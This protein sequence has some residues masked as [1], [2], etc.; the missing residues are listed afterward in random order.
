MKTIR[1]ETSEQ[2][3]DLTPWLR[4]YRTDTRFELGEGTFVVPGNWGFDDFDHVAL[5]PGCELI[6]AGSGR[7]TLTFPQGGYAHPPDAKQVECF[8]AGSRSGACDF[9]RIEGVSIEA[10]T[11]SGVASVGLH[12]WSDSCVVRD[13]AL[14]DISGSRSVAEG[15]GL[16]VNR[17]GERCGTAGGG[18]IE[19]V[20]VFLEIPVFKSEGDNYVCGCYVGIE[21]ADQPTIVRDVRVINPVEDVPA[22]AAFGTN[23]GV[24]WSGIRNVG[25]WRRAVFCDTAGGSGTLISGS[26]LQ[27]EN[28][29][30]EFRGGEN[31]KWRDIVVSGSML[32]LVQSPD[33]REYAA[34]LVLAT[35]GAPGNGS[36]AFEGVRLHG[37]TLRADGPSPKPH[38]F[39]FG[40]CDSPRSIACGVIQCHAVGNWKAPI[41]TNGSTGFLTSGTVRS[42]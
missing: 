41:Q 22:H 37:C 36:P 6:G 30:V 4:K 38:G 35:D 32:E 2:D 14:I 10:A 3:F 40:S 20:A 7:T 34:A 29:L 16:L 31:M 5:G 33:P 9:V 8:T 25:R 18:L 39:V 24:L 1:I 23:G 27:A 15:F 19:G 42:T 12:V 26:Q 28:V 13:V 17:A 11:Q 21:D